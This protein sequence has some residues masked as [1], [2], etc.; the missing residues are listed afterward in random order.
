MRTK[1]PVIRKS[2]KSI[3]SDSDILIKDRD[4]NGELVTYT[5]KI[6]VNVDFN[7][8]IRND[9]VK[10]KVSAIKGDSI[11]STK[12][13]LSRPSSIVSDSGIVFG[14]SQT[15]DSI[16]LK[17]GK[18]DISKSYFGFVDTVGVKTSGAS[19]TQILAQSLARLNYDMSTAFK[20][21]QKIKKGDIIDDNIVAIESFMN[22]QLRD[23]ATSRKKTLSD[24][25]KTG[26]FSK[27]SG[28][29]GKISR[30]KKPYREIKNVIL[31]GFDTKL[32]S[33][34][35]L[36]LQKDGFTISNG[37][38][39]NDTI[40]VEGISGIM[41]KKFGSPQNSEWRLGIDGRPTRDR[42]RSKFKTSVSSYQS[43][44]EAQLERGSKDLESTTAS[45][46]QSAVWKSVSLTKKSPTELIM[47]YA[48]D[49]VIPSDLNFSGIISN[50][51][52]PLNI[53]SREVSLAKKLCLGFKSS[54][55]TRKSSQSDATTEYVAVQTR[56]VLKYIEIPVEISIPESA[57]LDAGITIKID[58]LNST[59]QIV[60]TK[61]K[62]F[63][64]SEKK[65][66]FYS[67]SVPPSINA[68]I[69]TTGDIQVSVKQ[70]DKDADY[71]RV[72]RKYV[73]EE[74]ISNGEKFKL[75]NK[76]SGTDAS[77]ESGEKE[78]IDTL[79]KVNGSSIM[80]RAVS[81]T[82]SGGGSGAFSDF[83]LDISQ[84][85]NS[86]KKSSADFL[87][88]SIVCKVQKEGILI[89]VPEIK[90]DRG[91]SFIEKRRQEDGFKSVEKISNSNDGQR[92]SR[93]SSEYTFLDRDVNHG[94]TYHY[95]IMY[96][97][98]HGT[99]KRLQPTKIEYKFIFGDADLS[100][101]AINSSQKSSPVKSA[102]KLT[103]NIGAIKS[104][105]MEQASSDALSEYSRS[106]AA[107]A[108]SK[109]R[110]VKDAEEISKVSRVAKT[111][112]AGLKD[113]SLLA[114]Y[115]K[116]RG[117]VEEEA[118]SSVKNEIEKNIY[119]I[120]VQR[121]DLST[122][123]KTD[124]GI[125]MPGETYEDTTGLESGK[126][127]EYTFQELKM[128]MD[129]Y[130]EIV[131]KTSVSSGELDFKSGKTLTIAKDSTDKD[132]S[133]EDNYR[134]KFLDQSATI[135]GVIVSSMARARS[136]VTTL[137][138]NPSG[139]SKTVKV[140][141]PKEKTKIL[142]ASASAISNKRVAIK[143]IAAGS[144]YIN[145]E[146]DIDFFIIT[147]KK[148]DQ[149]YPVL[150]CHG[151]NIGSGNFIAIDDTQDKFVG[152]VSYFITPIYNNASVGDTVDAG[153]VLVR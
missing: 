13:L 70:I 53:S 93:V 125:F 115:L 84:L 37:I 89:S 131:T 19:Q 113:E 65:S 8:A 82:S 3:D 87:Q 140:T 110:A 2:L 144:K 59:G 43:D 100:V 130:S 31:D 1:L 123:E 41:Q 25:S 133:F 142:N 54:S 52:K 106:K 4:R 64:H 97:T 134:S 77:D 74:S 55:R 116:S 14:K 28:L 9:I 104:L 18:K 22:S 92:S 57:T 101:N 75:I 58:A 63:N 124:V 26:N 40:L 15:I 42:M 135:D 120:E 24:E 56:K 109:E 138:K 112:R 102:V 47:G 149:V 36:R 69:S 118:S 98:E 62:D 11:S 21:F 129:T 76:F 139:V 67:T 136:P 12:T 60:D 145:N 126:S 148:L 34:A 137:Q 108:S 85:V 94:F 107:S 23:Y 46:F 20:E 114:E 30:K 44:L 132:S 72:Y 96:I 7:I 45:T 6:I 71:L 119:S 32:I 99:E 51:Q 147:A 122:G 141:I 78:F 105:D 39:M 81:F 66:G 151:E 127:Y 143:W 68:K 152:E 33:Q 83:V 88:G 111:G 29:T 86:S 146:T 79:G 150:T 80:Y 27:S 61:K 48:K 121:T 10:V 73:S 5:Y 90:G 49:P 91:A 50:G 38:Q 35:E 153:T 128:P 95:N 117:K 16:T 103:M 17:D